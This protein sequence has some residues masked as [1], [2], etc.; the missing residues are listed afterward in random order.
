MHGWFSLRKIDVLI[1]DDSAFQRVLLRNLL[2][3]DPR[4]GKI[5]FGHDGL[6]GVK[7]TLELSPDVVILDIIMPRMDGI[8]ALKEIMEKKPTPVLLLSSLSREEI[9]KTLKGGLEAGAVDFL[10]KPSKTGEWRETIQP[11]LLRK[12]MAAARANVKR[13]QTP[14]SPKKIPRLAPRE[15]IKPSMLP[16]KVIVFAASTGGPKTLDMI[17]TQFPRITPPILVVQ[18]MDEKF[19]TSFAERLDTKSSIRVY[20]ARDGQSLRPSIGFVAPGGDYHMDLRQGTVPATAL[21]PGPKVNFVRPAAD[22]TMIGAARMFREGALG[23]VLTGMGRDGLE[24]AKAI[25]N[26]GGMVI[27]ESPESCVVSSMPQSVIDAGLADI[28]APKENI[29][30]SIRRLG[31]L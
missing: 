29:A 13:L 16:K 6:E 15:D 9:D 28:V 2:R 7:K 17:F 19:T 23:V 20:E 18:H 14:I 8:A 3:D 24:G 12:V 5:R 27:A 31:W 26:V 10:Q 25:K 22:I 11:Y 4:I 21:V 1:V 30:S